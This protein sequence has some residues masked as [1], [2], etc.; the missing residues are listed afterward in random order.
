[1]LQDRGILHAPAFWIN[2]GGV[3]NVAHEFH[4]GGY[5]QERAFADIKR[6]YDRGKEMIEISRKEK[7]PLFEA[8]MRLAEARI[9][10]AK[11]AG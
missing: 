8:A 2:G 4:P 5:S 10:K 7:L 9:R 6:I 1:M 3:I 11:M